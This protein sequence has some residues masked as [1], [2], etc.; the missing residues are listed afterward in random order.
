MDTLFPFGLPGATTT[1]LVLYVVT[2]VAHA[3]LVGYVL[4]GTAYVAVVRCVGAARGRAVDDA[5]APALLDWLPFGLGAAIT[6]GVAPLL[7]LQILYK[8]SFY[9]ANLLLFHRWMAVVPV[10]IVGFYA[11]YLAKTER[12]ARWRPWARAAIP[13]VATACFAFVAYSW[14][15]NHLLALD[16]SA[17]VPMYAAGDHMYTGPS[18]LARFALWLGF[19]GPIMAAI[20]GWQ[21]WA[22][23]LEADA[24]RVAARRLG[25]VAM[26]GLVAAVAPA[27]ILWSRL[28]E[29]SIE[30]VTSGAVAPHVVLAA[31][32][33]IA[34]LAGWVA[35]LRAGRIAPTW[36]AVCGAGAVLTVLGGAMVREA[37]RV[38]ALG[39]P[40]LFALHERASNAG[41]MVLFF[42]FVVVNG[43]A[44]AW[45]LRLTRRSIAR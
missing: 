4:A 6:A 28:P 24:A 37:L 21:L 36:L 15:E 10:L 43:A 20:A 7:F 42:V 13:L 14:T 18:T 41:G 23:Q 9:T 38:A 40:G 30:L 44:I 32:G 29:A 5:L 33:V 25:A 34:Q 45:C 16:K 27:A 8:E 12:A 11:L 31:V 17:W 1:Y 3:L 26:A 2:L 39:E 22:A 19:A 35:Q